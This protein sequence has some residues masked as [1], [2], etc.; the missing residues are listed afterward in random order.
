MR[1][2]AIGSN[3]RIVIPPP[4]FRFF[5]LNITLG[6]NCSPF[7]RS[8]LYEFTIR[9]SSGASATT[10][11]PD[12]TSNTTPSPNVASASSERNANTQAWECFD[13][14]LTQ[15]WRADDADAVPTFIKIDLGIG[16]EIIVVEYSL[17]TGSVNNCHPRDWTFEGSNDDSDYTVL[18][19]QTGQDSIADT[20]RDFSI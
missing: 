15:F 4:P 10:V 16:N 19:T 11:V 9:T 3:Q 18:D 8:R 12:M 7:N 6:N 17:R 1:R 14:D 5:Q 20:W 13:R 2:V